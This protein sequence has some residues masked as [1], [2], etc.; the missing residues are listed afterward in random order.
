MS[1]T[2]KLRS[3]QRRF[4]RLVDVHRL[5]AIVAR[6]QYGKTTL[7]AAIALKKMMKKVGH[8][9]IFGSAK[10]NLSRE[11]VRKE[12]EI[13][14]RGFQALAESTA[15]EV[16]QVVTFDTKTNLPLE[17]SISVDDF[18]ELF[19]QQRL[20]F[21]YYHTKTAYSRTKVVAL[22][23][24]TVGETGDLM[25]DEIGRIG[26]WRE[27]WEA[28]EP[29][30]SSNPDFRLLLATTPPP[31]DTHYSFEQLSPPIGTVF[32]A[33]KDGNIYV[34]EYGLKVLRVD[35]A[36]A[37]ADGIPV[38]DLNDGAPL[39]PDEHRKRAHD[40]DAW[41]RNYGCRFLTGGSAAIGLPQLHTAQERGKDQCMAVQDDWTGAWRNLLGNGTIGIG[42]DLASTE[43][44]TSNPSVV[45]VVEKVGTEYIVRLIYRWKTARNDVFLATIREALDLGGQR[46]PRR[47]C[48]DS[49]GT[50]LYA[51]VVRHEFC[52]ICPVQAVNASAK[53]IDP[54]QDANNKSYL[55]NMLV[56]TID[57]NKL[58]LPADRWVKDDLRLVIRERGGFDNRLDSAGN[59]G[60][61]FDA[62]KL[63]ILAASSA[64]GPVE[65]SAVAT[66]SI[67][68]AAQKTM[69][70]GGRPSSLMYY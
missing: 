34:S 51:D 13:I 57:D 22:R 28:I 52:G 70:S 58:M 15:V 47:L 31:D 67:G 17:A 64:S 38:Y 60:D 61:T 45:A 8:T 32:P 6:R 18:A 24:D 40:K 12:G 35:A 26:N 66:G 65:A 62:I 9:V 68:R 53:D 16:G 33:N 55:G 25:A 30:V 36:D 69:A 2:L 19:E 37:W 48:F 5:L 63:A 4:L 41:D 14:Q 43:S 23:P 46:T 54:H 21:R 44:G 59:H 3:G 11:I 56:N 50:G 20:E 7:F 29:I 1:G 42:A 39:S 49:T 27:T 10:L